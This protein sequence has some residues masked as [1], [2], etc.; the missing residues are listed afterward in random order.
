[1][2]RKKWIFANEGRPVF[3]EVWKW[4]CEIYFLMTFILSDC[5]VKSKLWIVVDVTHVERPFVVHC[6]FVIVTVELGNSL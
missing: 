4:N 3:F 1:M 5:E 6:Y 2:S